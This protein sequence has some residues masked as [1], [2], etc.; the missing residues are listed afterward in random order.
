MFSIMEIL[1][2][3]VIVLLLDYCN[4]LWVIWLEYTH[5][6]IL[7]VIIKGPLT[8]RLFLV[9][10]HRS[11]WHQYF[12]DSRDNSNNSLNLWVLQVFQPLLLKYFTYE[13]LCQLKEKVIQQHLIQE[14]VRAMGLEKHV[15]Q[16]Y[17]NLSK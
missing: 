5:W 17:T 14:Q 1:L 16:E 15:T 4:R 8:K 7:H 6:T 13:E 11:Y 3:E 10:M 12:R 9:F 2:N